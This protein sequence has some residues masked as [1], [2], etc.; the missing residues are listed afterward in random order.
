MSTTLIVTVDTEEEGLWGGN[1]PATGNT[2]RNID[3]VGPFQS[4]CDEFGV[5][6]TYLVTAPVVEEAKAIDG[7]A[8]IANDGRCE[9]GAHVHPWCNPPFDEK[10]AKE[11]YLCN[12]PESL[13]HQKIEWLTD[14]ISGRVG[15]RPTSFR[16]GRYGLDAVGLGLLEQLNYRVDSSVIPFTDYSK[17]RGPDFTAAPF[18]PYFPAEDSLCREG[19]ARDIVEVPVGVGYWSGDF[20]QRFDWQRATGRFPWN[21]LRIEGILDRLGFARRIKCSPEQASAAAMNR[22]V[23]RYV[24]LGIPSLV[25]MFHSSSLLPGASP[26]VPDAAARDEF[27][28]RLRIVFQYAL[29]QRRLTASTLTD[30]ADTWSGRVT[31]QKLT[32]GTVLP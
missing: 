7:L 29:Q 28:N 4:L 19:K 11:T 5:Q 12:F 27:L 25:M 23:D 24:E 22:L 31:G 20:R 32:T 18:E 13:Q 17:Q 1:Y 15:I 3:H 26:Y 21:K 8:G 6:P 16:A 30:F 10:F 9:I 14:R 2:V